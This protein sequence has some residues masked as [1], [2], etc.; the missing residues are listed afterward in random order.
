MGGINKGL[1]EFN[2]KKL[3]EHVIQR[4]DPV[5]T[6]RVISANDNL[7][8]YERFGFPVIADTLPNQLGPLSGIYSAMKFL[9][10]EWLLVV[11]CDVPF[12]PLGYVQR[13][14]S[15]DGT[16]KTYVAFD[17]ERQHSG[18]CLLHR[19]LQPDLLAS[20][21]NN[22]LAVHHFLAEHGVQQIDFSDQA[23]A[24]TNI[25]TPEQLEALSHNV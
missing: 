25:N 6:D 10:K 1:I 16:A 11:P 4:L 20:L 2:G 12:L 17:G 8:I 7:P 13:M 18:C 24:F 14:L 19:S 22:L 15:H 21:E 9:H 23:L 5:V 3:I